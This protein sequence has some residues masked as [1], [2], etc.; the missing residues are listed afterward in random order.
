MSGSTNLTRMSLMAIDPKRL[1]SLI[2]ED[3]GDTPISTAVYCEKCTYLLKML[4]RMGR[5]PECG[6][7]YQVTGSKHMGIIEPQL[8]E[9]PAFDI[10]AASACLLLLTWLVNGLFQQLDL[11]ILLVA[12]VFACLAAAFVRRAW[13]GVA[14]YRK[15]LRIIRATMEEDSP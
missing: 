5:C 7:H 14:H 8:A 2:D 9:F 6:H 12:A 11:W 4:P 13:K 15:A 10:G 1:S 3:E